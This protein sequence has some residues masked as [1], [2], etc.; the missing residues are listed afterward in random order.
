MHQPGHSA[1]TGGRGHIPSTRPCWASSPK[2]RL[3]EEKQFPIQTHPSGPSQQLGAQGGCDG[4]VRTVTLGPV[5]GSGTP[6][7]PTHCTRS[8]QGLRQRTPGP[9]LGSRQ[10]CRPHPRASAT[11]PPSRSTSWHPA[12]SPHPPRHTDERTAVPQVAGRGRGAAEV[13]PCLPDLPFPGPVP[14]TGLEE[15]DSGQT[16]V[17]FLLSPWEWWTWAPGERWTPTATD[18]HTHACLCDK[19]H[20]SSPPFPVSSWP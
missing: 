16:V 3:K 13:R 6:Q 11:C 15:D 14:W 19:G 2:E 12:S 18:T 17:G 20:S 8:A 4:W 10:H 7:A 1:P 5:P 9:A